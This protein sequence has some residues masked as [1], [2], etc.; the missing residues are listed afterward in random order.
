[1]EA[2]RNKRY[3]LG[4][5]CDDVLRLLPGKGFGQLVRPASRPLKGDWFFHGPPRVEEEELQAIID[6]SSGPHEIA[7]RLRELALKEGAVD[8]N[9]QNAWGEDEMRTLLKRCGFE[10]LED[11]KQLSRLARRS[12]PDFDSMAHFSKF[13]YAKKHLDH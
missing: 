13:Y 5:I 3:Y 8:F 7:L 12:I 11:H 10:L 1:M 2:S 6:A 9:H 4:Q